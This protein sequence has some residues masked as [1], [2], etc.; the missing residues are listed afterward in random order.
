[1]SRQPTNVK[2]YIKHME[3]YHNFSGGLNT[4]TTI[5][6]LKNNEFPDL[7]NIDLGER[8]SLMR[9]YGMKRHAVAL[10]ESVKWKHIGS[11][12]WSEM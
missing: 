12:K 5:E 4:V 11:M 6:N 8:G 3:S 7:S 9:R 10:T 2:P 1:M